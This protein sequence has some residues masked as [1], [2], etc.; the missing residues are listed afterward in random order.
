MA[1]EPEGFYLDHFSPPNDKGQ[2]LALHI[3]SAIKNTE[4]KQKHA[5]IGSDGTP[6]ITGQT[7]KLIAALK[8]LLKRPL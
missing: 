5:L 1:G 8:R 6:S 7:N 3:H 2:T 4:L